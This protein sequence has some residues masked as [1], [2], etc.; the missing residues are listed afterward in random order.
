[1]GGDGGYGGNGS[2]YLKN[3]FGPVGNP[4]NTF[5]GYDPTPVGNIGGGT[6]RFR[7]NLRFST[8]S[9]SPAAVLVAELQAVINRA[10]AAINQLNAGRPEAVLMI[11]VPAIP[12]AAAPAGP[13]NDAY[14]VAVDW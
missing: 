3:T 6:G 7:V 8:L 12:R 14:E 2:V 11:Q 10:N 4:S 5:N 13:P 1:M 9:G